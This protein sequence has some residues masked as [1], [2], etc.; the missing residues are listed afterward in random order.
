RFGSMENQIMADTL[1]RIDERRLELDPGYRYQYVTQFTGFGERDIDA[2]HG[3]AKHLP[4]V[5][6][7]L[8][9]AVNVQLFRYDATQRHFVPRQFGYEGLLPKD[10]ESLTLDD[11]QIKFRKAHLTNYL[12]R[13]V[14]GTY[15]AKMVGYLDMVG[16]I[17]TPKGGNKGIHVPLVQM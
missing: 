4:P 3:M 15:D 7:A 10:L 6:P 17:H 11:E 2:I 5:A 16:R 14:S 13:L 1:Q 12:V 9:N 8:V